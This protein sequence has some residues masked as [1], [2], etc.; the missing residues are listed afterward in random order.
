MITDQQYNKWLKL[1]IVICTNKQTAKDV[2][3]ELLI[4]IIENDIEKEKLNDNYIF[5]SLRNRYLKHIN[6]EKKYNG[7]TVLVNSDSEQIFS[8]LK[9]IEAILLR[10]KASA[11]EAKI[12]L[13]LKK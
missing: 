4:T 8:N 12:D 9:D 3:H 13:I 5:I 2:L 1:S 11:R 10:E 7:N 6:S